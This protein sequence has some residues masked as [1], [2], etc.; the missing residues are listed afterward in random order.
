MTVLK[1]PRIFH[2]FSVTLI[3]LS[4]AIVY[5]NAV[6]SSF[7]FDDFRQIVSNDYIKGPDAYSKVL[8]NE[9][10]WVTMLTF[11]FEWK[12]WGMDA[13]GYHMG[14]ILIHMLASVLAYSFLVLTARLLKKNEKNDPFWTRRFP[15]FSALLFAL[16]PIQTQ[17][18]TYIIQRM[19][20]LSALFYLLA[21]IFFIKAA[22]S[23]STIKKWLWYG[24]V[25]LG[26][27]LSFY[28]KE[29]AIT[30]PVVVLLYDIYFIGGSIRT[31]W[32]R[33]PLYTVLSTLLVY[34]TITTVMPIGGFGELVSRLTSPQ[35]AFAE[36]P[37]VMRFKE[38]S[39]GFGI[40][41]ISPKDYLYTE[42]NV[43]VY[44]ITLLI[45]P[46]NQNLDYDFPISKRF[47]DMPYVMEG[48]ILN[49]P[50]PPPAISLAIILCIMATAAYLYIKAKRQ[51]KKR[52][53]LVSSF[54]IFWFFIL[55]APTSSFIPIA[56]VIFE[57]RVY[58]ASLGFFA[59]FVIAIENVIARALK[60]RGKKTKTSQ[61]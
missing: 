14:N 38:P 52:D 51:D 29:T 35:E 18:V 37:D 4:I 44:Y 19:E 36:E 6:G 47:F 49:I 53:P 13:K 17:S 20:S 12:N 5:S 24:A 45:I 46:A 54:F 26:F 40:K 30:L 10:R 25:C 31:L 33:W 9:M 42:F 58:L 60:A 7:H 55:L 1:N 28:S 15:L 61:Y 57:H 27:V 3:I 48:N 34:F 50:I 41:A 8:G 16:H 43:I 2:L 22:T 59:V 21:L 32:G 39:A 23:G 11:A 56:D